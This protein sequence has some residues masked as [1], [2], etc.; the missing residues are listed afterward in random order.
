RQVGG[1]N[2]LDGP[3]LPSKPAI[4]AIISDLESLLFPGFKSEEA[5]APG[6]LKYTI[7]E[8]ISRV[9]RNLSTEIARSLCFERRIFEDPACAGPG[10]RAEL[11]AC[12]AESEQ[13]ALEI[14]REFPRIRRMV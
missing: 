8:T 14:L 7:A 12:R 4:Q 9:L 2:H 5:I 11:S 1:I 3:N 10:E 6:S 13:L